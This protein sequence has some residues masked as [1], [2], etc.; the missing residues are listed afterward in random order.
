MSN[1][2]NNTSDLQKV[3]TTLV[4]SRNEVL[5]V[6]HGGTGATTAEDAR[7]QLGITPANIGAAPAYTY[8]TTDLTAGSSTLE[9][10]KLYF[11]YE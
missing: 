1:F 3:L 10:G 6:A 8:G 4:N 2:L 9:T 7:N 5:D 11:V